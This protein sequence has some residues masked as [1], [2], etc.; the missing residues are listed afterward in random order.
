MKHESKTQQQAFRMERAKRGLS[1][2]DVAKK[3]GVTRQRINRLE[4]E[5]RTEITKTT[6]LFA[7]LCELYELNPEEVGK[8]VDAQ[9]VAEG[10]K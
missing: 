8:M 1:T 4:L 6:R 10:K 5:G 3:L 2:Q 7:P 9:R